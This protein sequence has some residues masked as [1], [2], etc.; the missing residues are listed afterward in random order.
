MIPSLYEIGYVVN[1]KEGD[2]SLHRSVLPFTNS[3][4]NL[5]HVVTEG[6]TLLSISQKYYNDQFLWYIIADANP[7]LTLDVFDIPVN[8]TLMVPPHNILKLV[9]G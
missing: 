9:Y 7:L 2:S 4:E 6:E 3:T 8:T 1:Y 5:Y